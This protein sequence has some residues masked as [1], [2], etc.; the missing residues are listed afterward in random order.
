MNHL[1]CW[2]VPT[3]WGE[4]GLKSKDQPFIMV[5]DNSAL[6][7]GTSD[8]EAIQARCALELYLVVMGWDLSGASPYPWGMKKAVIAQVLGLYLSEKGDLVSCD[9]G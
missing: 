6:F 9:P 5:I 2:P 4:I 7:E 1:L 8:A 3:C